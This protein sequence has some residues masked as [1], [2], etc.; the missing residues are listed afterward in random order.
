MVG[1]GAI[2]YHH[3]RGVE[4]LRLDC[5]VELRI[6]DPD[7]GARKRLLDVVPEAM[8]FPSGEAMLA[9]PASAGDIVIVAVPPHLHFEVTMLGLRS[10][11]HVLCEKPLMVDSRQAKIALRTAQEQAVV[12][13][14]C[15][16]RHVSTRAAR[17]VKRLVGRGALGD[18]YRMRFVHR[19]RRRRPGVEYQSWSN[20]F[21]DRSLSGG[22]VLMDWGPYDIAALNHLLKPMAVEVTDAWVARPEASRPGGGVVEADVEFH[23][24]ASLRFHMSGC[25][26]LPVTYE[27]ACCMH[28]RE[29]AV[30]ELE[31]R[32]GSV[33]WDW[34][35]DTGELV[36]S[37]DRNG[38]PIE[39]SWRFGV[40][41]VHRLERPLI[42]LVRFLNGA[43]ADVVINEQAVFNLLCLLAIDETAADGR[44]RR[45]DR[46]FMGGNQ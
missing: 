18:L 27:R 32:L 24:G 5:S 46:D 21:L 39:S 20:W 37:R 13:A 22:G 11:R 1:A 30:A 14:C 19:Y 38:E 44:P 15:S 45:V 36:L 25:S 12:L 9:E 42:D 41:P 34:I 26:P 23:V 4:R 6:A 35:G 31:G 7:P 40:E 43:D 2:A 33:R 17:R 29:E 8:E 3:V 16:G 10:G 28:G